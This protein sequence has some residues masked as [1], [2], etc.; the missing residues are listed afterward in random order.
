MAAQVGFPGLKVT[1][2]SYGWL[3]WFPWLLDCGWLPRYYIILLSFLY[4]VLLYYCISILLYDYITILL[5]YC[6]II[7][8]YCVKHKLESLD[9]KLQNCSKRAILVDFGHFSPPMCANRR[10]L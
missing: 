4:I 7:L 2:V 1:D 9:G 3:L 5:Y 10:V 8:Y 6:I